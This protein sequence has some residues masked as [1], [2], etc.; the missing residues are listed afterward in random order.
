MDGSKTL[1]GGDLWNVLTTRDERL[2]RSAELFEWIRTGKLRVTIARRFRLSE[3]A[4]AHAFL[5]SRRSI[6][7]VLFVMDDT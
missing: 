2:R 7:K 5:E 1:T 3:G 4:S 6:G